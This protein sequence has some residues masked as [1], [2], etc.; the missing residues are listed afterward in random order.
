MAFPLVPTT[1]PTAPAKT[2]PRLVR[3]RDGAVV[4]ERLEVA[5]TFLG[6]LR[7]LMG[8]RGID[9]GAGL[10]IEPCS[11]IHMMFVRFPIDAVW[12]DGNGT[13]LKVSPAVTPWMVPSQNTPKLVR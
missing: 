11:S 2:A 12:V 8:R 1:A 3:E 9:A 5:D 6:R 4:A 10:W 13:V 7:G